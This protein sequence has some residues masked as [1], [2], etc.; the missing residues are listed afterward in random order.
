[1]RNQKDLFLK[2]RIAV[3]G[4]REKATKSVV[5]FSHLFGQGTLILGF[6][7]DLSRFSGQFPPLACAVDSAAEFFFQKQKIARF[8]SKTLH[9]QG[10]YPTIGKRKG[11]RYGPLTRYSNPSPELLP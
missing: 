1:M 2:P 11:F 9:A 4:M 3:F 8:D 6:D 5:K 10:P 7:Y